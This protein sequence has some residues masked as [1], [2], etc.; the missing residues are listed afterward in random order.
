MLALA[1]GCKPA[2][3]DAGTASAISAAGPD[4]TVTL[5]ASATTVTAV[6]EQVDITITVAV[7]SSETQKA[8]GVVA[9]YQAPARFKLVY[10]RASGLPQGAISNALTIQTPAGAVTNTA[11]A[12]WHTA[13]NVVDAAGKATLSI[14][15]MAPGDS[16]AY[17]AVIEYVG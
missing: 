16:R 12:T 3:F 2:G 4:P 5:A 10:V 14:G 6:G 1:I 11:A 9:T 7:P 8:M 17:I 15:A 13:L